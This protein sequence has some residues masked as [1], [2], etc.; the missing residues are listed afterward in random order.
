MSVAED[1]APA[2]GAQEDAPRPK[3]YDPTVMDELSSSKVTGMDP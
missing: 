2:L 1:A 3:Q